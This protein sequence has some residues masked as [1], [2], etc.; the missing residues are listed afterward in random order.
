MFVWS[1]G[2]ALMRPLGDSLARS[3]VVEG[4]GLDGYDGIPPTSF[5]DSLVGCESFRVLQQG[6]GPYH[7]LCFA[8]NES[9][10]RV[11]LWDGN[12]GI[13]VLCDRGGFGICWYMPC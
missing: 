10:G 9:F 2:C 12:G 6:S 5:A 8:A 13:H 4:R 1:Y 7:F 3:P 11:K